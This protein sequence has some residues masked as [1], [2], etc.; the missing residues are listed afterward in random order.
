[1]PE[2][3]LEEESFS[4]FPPLNDNRPLV[5]DESDEFSDYYEPSDSISRH[6]IFDS[7]QPYLS[8]QVNVVA[9]DKVAYNQLAPKLV[10]EYHHHFG[11]DLEKSRS[12]RIISKQIQSKIRDISGQKVRSPGTSEES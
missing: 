9:K 3:S 1:M 4:A 2:S 10:P 7:E 8:K 5:I 12:T 11:N 6:N